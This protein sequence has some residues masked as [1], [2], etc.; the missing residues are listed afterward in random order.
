VARVRRY[1]RTQ[2]AGR[3]LMA[4]YV[5][6]IEPYQFRQLVESRFII[7]PDPADIDILDDILKVLQN[8]ATHFGVKVEL[9]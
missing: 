3:C 8:I 6:E 5:V 1:A 7:E 9:E 2:S 4:K